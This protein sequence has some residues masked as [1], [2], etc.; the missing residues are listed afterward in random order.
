MARANGYSKEFT[1]PLKSVQLQ[2]AL[3]KRAN[4]RRALLSAWIWVL[5]SFFCRRLITVPVFTDLGNVIFQKVKFSSHIFLY[6]FAWLS[7][8]QITSL[9]NVL[10]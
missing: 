8:N 6:L 1:L 4:I 10:H 9:D 3:P 5:L 2:E 7:L